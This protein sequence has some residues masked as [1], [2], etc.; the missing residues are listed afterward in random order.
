[1]AHILISQFMVK[2]TTYSRQLCAYLTFVSQRKPSYNNNVS[3]TVT[4]T[5][6]TKLLPEFSHLLHTGMIATVP[7]IPQVTCSERSS[8]SH[9]IE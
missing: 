2:M 9:E 8:S 5:L 3:K 7:R 4:Q 6:F 1:M